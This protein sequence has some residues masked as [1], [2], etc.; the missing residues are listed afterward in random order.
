M[1]EQS[2]RNTKGG[3]EEVNQGA[4]ERP[5]GGSAKCESSFP[6]QSLRYARIT[7]YFTPGVG[8]STAALDEV[9]MF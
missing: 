1:A 9:Q 5:P 3:A 4:G 8:T 2:P 7:D 6:A